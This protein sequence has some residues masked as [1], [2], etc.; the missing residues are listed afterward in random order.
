MGKDARIKALTRA[1]RASRPGRTHATGGLSA[2]TVR[3]A[4]ARA[5]PPA[6]TFKRDRVIV[7]ADLPPLAER[8]RAAQRAIAEQG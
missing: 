8:V 1:E 7:R 3:R 6:P 5:H 2:R 4:Y